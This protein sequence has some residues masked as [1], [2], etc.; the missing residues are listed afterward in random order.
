M[1][2][3]QVLMQ[4]V[5][6]CQRPPK[7]VIIVFINL[8]PLVASFFEHYH[9][10]ELITQVTF[11]QWFLSSFCLNSLGWSTNFQIK[12]YSKV[13]DQSYRNSF[14]TESFLNTLTSINAQLTGSV[15]RNHIADYILCNVPRLKFFLIYLVFNLFLYLCYSSLLFFYNHA[16]DILRVLDILPNFAFVTSEIERGYQ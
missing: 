8:I 5:L 14:C 2:M 3:P 9:S 1:T 11:F 16:R 7:S 6:Y 10:R 13:H 4:A 15:C 12:T